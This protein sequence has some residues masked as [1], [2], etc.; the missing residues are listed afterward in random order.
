MTFLFWINRSTLPRTSPHFHAWTINVLWPDSGWVITMGASSF[1]WVC[2]STMRS[3]PLT[4]EAN[5]LEPFSRESYIPIC[6]KAITM[7]AF[8]LNSGTRFLATLISSSNTRFFVCS[9]FPVNSVSLVVRPKMAVLNPSNSFT[10]YGRVTY[11]PCLVLTL[12]E[13]KGN[14]ANFICS[15]NRSS[16]WSNSWFPRTMAS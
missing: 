7:S 2:P 10:M 3:I 12:A 4:S 14:S 9:G 16:G 6:T 8:F 5:L 15:F 1:V 13:R 11:G